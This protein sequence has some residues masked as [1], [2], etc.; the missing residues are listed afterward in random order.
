MIIRQER[1][2]HST[3]QGKGC[4]RSHLALASVGI[5]IALMMV[6]TPAQAATMITYAIGAPVPPIPG[7]SFSWLHTADH[8]FGSTGWYPGANF[9]TRLNGN[10]LGS[11]DGS[12]LTFLSGTLNA[13]NDGPGTI[14]VTGGAVSSIGTGTMTYTSAGFTGNYSAFNGSG[15]FNYDGT[16]F[17]VNNVSATEL[18][19]WGQNFLN[20]TVPPPPDSYGTDLYGV[21]TT[22]PIVTP[23]PITGL[24]LGI[25]LAGLIGLRRKQSH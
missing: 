7:F 22:V 8:E 16:L 25:G 14:T 21:G 24:L 20:T 2:Q 9:Q 4:R 13:P 15:T 5:L 23:E 10:I 1:R 11:W 3:D 17:T 12:T 19:L 6:A 18:V